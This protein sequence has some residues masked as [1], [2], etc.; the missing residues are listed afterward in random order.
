[1]LYRIC[2]YTYRTF[3]DWKVRV[4]IQQ[5]FGPSCYTHYYLL[6]KNEN[7]WCAYVNE[8]LVPVIQFDIRVGKGL[9]GM[10]VKIFLQCDELLGEIFLVFLPWIDL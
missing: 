3:L 5:L 6:E 10:F 4:H 1:M 2:K 9:L 8:V 7:N